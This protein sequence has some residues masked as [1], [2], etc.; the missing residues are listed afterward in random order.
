MGAHGGLDIRFEI[1]GQDGAFFIDSTRETGI[2]V[3]TIALEDKVGYIV[4]KAE[5]KKGWMFPQWSEHIYYGYFD[6]LKHFVSCIA[7]DERPR[8]TFKDGYM[9]NCI[10]DAC[11]RSIKSRKWERLTA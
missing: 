5:A 4:E 6:E 7:K 1:Y 11:Y 8:E 10:L 9:V 3:F 2:S